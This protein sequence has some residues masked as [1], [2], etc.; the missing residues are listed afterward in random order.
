MTFYKA[1]VEW[2]RIMNTKLFIKKN[3]ISNPPSTLWHHKH[4]NCLTTNLSKVPQLFDPFHAAHIYHIKCLTLYNTNVNIEVPQISIPM[5]SH[6]AYCVNSFLCYQMAAVRGS[7]VTL[8][9]CA[10]LLATALTAAGESDSAT[11]RAR[12]QG[13]TPNGKR[14]QVKDNI[15]G[16]LKI[17]PT[18]CADFSKFIFGIELYMFRTGFLSI[19]RSPALYTQQ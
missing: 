2:N 6:T 5:F 8:L 14:R 11:K 3:S 18:K 15:Q 16:V 7:T 4:C 1:V 12:G 19:I 9:L 17:K 10:L 13:R